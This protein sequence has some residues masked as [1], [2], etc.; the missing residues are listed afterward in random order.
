MTDIAKIEY[1]YSQ[2][3]DWDAT[4]RKLSVGEIRACELTQSQYVLMCQ[5]RK[6]LASEEAKE[7]RI[8]KLLLNGSIYCV[9]RIR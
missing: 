7:Y 6:R 3:I 4:L 8:R 2:R 1:E 5:A 9:S